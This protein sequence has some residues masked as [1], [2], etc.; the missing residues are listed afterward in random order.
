M[1]LKTGPCFACRENSLKRLRSLLQRYKCRRVVCDRKRLKVHIISNR[2]P[3]RHCASL[4]RMT[5]TKETK[6]KE[7]E[8]DHSTVQVLSH[9][10]ACYRIEAQSCPVS[11]GPQS[12]QRRPTGSYSVFFFLG[13]VGLV[14]VT[15]T[16]NPYSLG[17][18]FPTGWL[19]R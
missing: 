1:S 13:G 7:E 2:K 19:M 10:R 3:G 11:R 17:L 8:E 9:I 14:G 16:I 15:T 4:D 18:P 12:A 6:E 5:T